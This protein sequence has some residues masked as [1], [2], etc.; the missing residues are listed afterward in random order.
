MSLASLLQSAFSRDLT[1]EE[2]AAEVASLEDRA[3]TKPRK[4]LSLYR[5]AARMAAQHGL[6]EAEA[7]NSYQLGLLLRALK[8]ARKAEAALSRAA[9]IWGDLDDHLNAGDAHLALAGVCLMDRR[10]DAAQAFADKARDH[11]KAADALT[12]RPQLM[13]LLSA[14]AAVRAAQ[15]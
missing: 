11:Y 8:P 1:P 9:E 13:R 12:E 15:A 14:I 10:A 3:R 5:K 4:A 2:V 6:R 7:R